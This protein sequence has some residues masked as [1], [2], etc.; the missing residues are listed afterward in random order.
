MPQILR[1]LRIL[2][3]YRNFLELCFAVLVS[4][5]GF[6]LILPLLPIY[7]REMGA[8]DVYLG[9]LTSLF[10]IT[11]IITS[12]FG[13]VL[14]DRVGRKRLIVG[15]LL[16]Y[17]AVMFLFGVS[18]N[19][20][21]LLIL[22]ACQGAASGV[23]WPVAAT[24]VADIVE[25]KDRGKAMGVFSMMWDTGMAVGPVLGGLLS[26]A[27]TI[28]I[29]FFVCSALSLV[30]ALLIARRVKETHFESE[31]E[32]LVSLQSL[33]FNKLSLIGVCV[34]GFT[35][36]FAMGLVQPILPL[37][38]NEVIGLDEASIG[39]VFG[40]MGI[41]RFLVKPVSGTLADTVGRKKVAV[42][43]LITN[44][45]FTT[46]I[47]FSK[48]FVSILTLSAA[49]AVGLG[50]TM[51]SMNAL[52]TSLTTKEKRGKVMGIYS[53]SRNTG[54]AV[55]PLLGGYTFDTLSVQAPFL[56]CGVAV[57]LGM[58]VLIA[59]VTEPDENVDQ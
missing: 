29:P 46:S 31:K 33:S 58:S 5:I 8:S 32:S 35:V 21:H 52:V 56:I 16:A 23:V 26:A 47:S 28:A 18:T 44:G 55:G 1:E 17:T 2:T 7:G 41:A 36:S 10:A 11:R 38:G 53:A 48:T 12:F 20:Y 50:M 15:G 37:F 59:T 39:L 24:M 4:M 3:K 51:P 57:F 19:L 49:R 34:T 13:G 9:L 54:L 42:M 22:R 45:I 6:G 25:S 40:A 27:F 30:S 43:G 14:A